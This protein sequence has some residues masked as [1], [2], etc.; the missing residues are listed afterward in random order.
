MCIC[1]MILLDPFVSVWLG[2]Q[3]IIEKSVTAA[4]VFNI[5]VGGLN[6]PFYTFRVTSGIFAP[7][8]YY[9]VSYAVV[10]IVLSIVLGSQFG[11]AGVFAA[12]FFARLIC[13]EWKEGKVVFGDILQYKFSQ[14][15]LKYSASVGVLLV[16][17]CVVQFVV[18]LVRIEGWGGLFIK[19]I[20]CFL[21]V[22]MA[23][24]V[25]FAKTKAFKG[26]HKKAKNLFLGIQIKFR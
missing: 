12:T 8:K 9:Y 16:T 23:F 14:F 7:M 4:L 1:F 11:L 3:Y 13:V 5:F 6:F 25:I 17:Y 19:A 20:I 10:N 15:L 21:T 2:A 24:C 26:L 22:N 18:D